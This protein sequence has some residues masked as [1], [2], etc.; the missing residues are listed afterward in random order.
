M[1]NVNLFKKKIKNMKYI[2]KEFYLSSTKS[3]LNQ[4]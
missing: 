1:Q 4:I 3:R 2:K